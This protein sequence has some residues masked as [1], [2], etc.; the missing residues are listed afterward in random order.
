MV[1]P[2]TVVLNCCVPPVSSDAEVGE[3]VID[4]TVGAVTVTAADADLVVST[5]L[6]A[7]TV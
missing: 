4:T 1:V 3:M 5:A 6:V 2:V 7:V